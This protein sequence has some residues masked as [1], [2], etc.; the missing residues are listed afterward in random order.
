MPFTIFLDMLGFGNKVGKISDEKEAKEFIVFMQSN[1]GIFKIIKDLNNQCPFNI[2]NNNYEFKFSFISDSIIILAYPL[3]LDNSITKDKYYQ[4]SVHMFMSL[5]NKLLPLFFNLWEH[6]KILLRGG[7]SNKFSYI[8]NEFVVGE[9]LIEAYKLES[10][11]NGAIYPRI[12][13]SKDITHDNKFM[14]TLKKNSKSLYK[15]DKNIIT[16]DKQDDYFFLH[17]FNLLQNQEQNHLQIKESNKKFYSFHKEAI[18]EMKIFM[19]SQ[20]GK[21]DFEKIKAKYN[22][23]KSYHN[24]NVPNEYKILSEG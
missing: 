13:L 19:D 22:W 16:K 20:E 11:D 14:E 18:E 2:I 6:K 8:E 10:K 12:I 7:I 1:K 4:L 17:Y 9:G 21:K 24:E 15:T 5:Y 23:I 3:E